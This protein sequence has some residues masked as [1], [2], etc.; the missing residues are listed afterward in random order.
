LAA[1]GFK[2]LVE[3]TWPALTHLYAKSSG[4][5]LEDPHALSAAAFA[6]FPALAELHLSGVQLGEAGARLL[7][8]RRWTRLKYLN[9]HETELGGAGVAA[10]ARGAWPAL[11]RLDLRWN[12]LGSLLRLED[13]RRWVPALKEL[14]VVAED[15]EAF[16]GSSTGA[17]EL[18]ARAWSG[19]E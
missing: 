7:A 14:E 5:A 9:L 15:E 3:A 4:V 11:E 16:D 19:S 17:S 12:R 18:S 13:A 2:A 6:G 10:L 1:A 8:S